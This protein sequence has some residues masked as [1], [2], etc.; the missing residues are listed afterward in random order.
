MTASTNL[1]PINVVLGTIAGAGA[2]PP[3]RTGLIPHGAQT[4][5]LLDEP[6]EWNAFSVAVPTQPGAW[7]SALVI[8]GM[9]CA[10]CSITVEDALSK[11]PGVLSVR[12][13]AAT[14][15]AHVVWQQDQV[16]PSQWMLEV[17]RCGYRAA[18]ANDVFASER[19]RAE[20]RK[21]LW[22][23]LVAGL[24]MM[25]VMMYAY[26]AYIAHPGDLTQE[27]ESLLRWASWVLTLPVILFS[28][29]PFF[30]S[31][32][33]DVL[34]A[35]VSMDLPV[36][37]GMAITFAVS[38]VGTFEPN[39]MFGREVYFD[40]LT[41]FVFF[42]LTGRWL[43]LRL[44][45]RTAGALEALMN[46][47]PDSVERQKAD[48][49]Y[50]RVA[51]R[52]VLVGDVLRVH[53]G[54]AFLAD[55]E[56]LEGNTSVDE[57][58]L[59]GESKPLSRGPGGQVV[60]GSHNLSGTVLMR[61]VRVGADTRFSQIVALMETASAAKPGNTALVDRL[62]KPFLVGVLVAAVAACAWWWPQDP[63]H[64][65]MVAVAVLVVTCPCA[66]SLAT[67]AAV[68]ASAGALA[69]CG[70]L[71]RKLDALDTLA[72]VDTVVFDKTGTLTQD[73]MVLAQVHTRAEFS[74]DQALALA[75]VLASQ[76]LHPASRAIAAA[77]EQGVVANSNTAGRCA[78]VG[79]VQELAGGGLAGSVFAPSRADIE[80]QVGRTYQLRL[81][82][83][84][85]CGVPS[86]AAAHVRVFM[87]D[88]D[89]WLATFDLA[90]QVRAQ[91]RGV[92]AD[93]VARGL[94]VHLLSG[95]EEASV[96]AVAHSVGIAKMR[97][98]CLPADK[99]AYLSELQRAGHTVAMVGD[100][101]NDGPVLAG[102]NVAFAFGSAVPLAQSKADFVVMGSSLQGVAQTLGVAR[103]TRDVIRQ[104]LWWAL[105]YN[106][107]CVPLAVA[108]MLPAW[109]AGLGMAASSLLVVLNALRLARAPRFVKDE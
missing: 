10:A 52:R 31:A 30:K 11:V 58:L 96:T 82:S 25:Q 38:T 35:R 39:G 99:L 24:C 37:L 101:L 45:D 71:V 62:A 61:V 21:A 69:R 73:A 49:S 77:F 14:H 100:G 59:T 27:M 7:D 54:E 32:L 18:P 98:A 72:Q 75:A 107:A 13:N 51:G 29:G 78:L 97:S 16:L 80:G 41:M 109:A 83:A 12:V 104:N 50:E 94:D 36:A 93:L 5:R 66:L 64:A 22:R 26:P 91:A 102:A 103:K 89:G 95:D 79:D 84:L 6:S 9:H 44:R 108:G 8:E 90:E 60:A 15:R 53:A 2:L 87:S 23:W 85:H 3:E 63:T 47:L 76:S 56:V 74:T 4:L 68:L 34:H 70:I 88:Q 1:P 57:A 42:L 17:Q 19:R 46:R 48:G 65:V 67:P 106:A 40:S 55:G 92:V 43:E 86:D 81:G 105:L 20:T 28:C 33:R